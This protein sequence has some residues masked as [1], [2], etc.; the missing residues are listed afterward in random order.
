MLKRVLPI[1]CFT[2]T[3]ILIGCG[4]GSNT[5]N[6]TTNT[7]PTNA[8]RAATNTAAPANTGSANTGS[9]TASSGEKI[10][11]PECDDFLAK[12]E[13]CV[14]GKV[15]AA[16]RAQF[17]SSMKQWRDSWHKLAENPQTKGTLAQACKTSLESARTSMKS[18]GCEF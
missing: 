3:A 15:P 1:L 11:V 8:N 13:A 5:N 4:G 2:A 9:T 14:T 16:A 17:E 7:G 18:F 6:S 12:Y 10:G